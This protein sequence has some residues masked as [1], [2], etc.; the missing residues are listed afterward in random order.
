M[1]VRPAKCSDREL[2]HPVLMVF[3]IEE[4]Y[5]EPDSVHV[6]M[7]T[8]TRMPHQRRNA[9]CKEI[10]IGQNDDAGQRHNQNS[11]L[12]LHITTVCFFAISADICITVSSGFFSG[13]SAPPSLSAWTA[14]SVGIL[15]IISSCA[16]GQPPSP[17]MAE[18][19]RRQP[20]SYAAI[21]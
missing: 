13:T 10:R 1:I 3:F 12:R 11:S 19:N 16:N 20:A 6:Y 5:A 2:I 21:I 14:I 7:I 17:P 15:P 8:M 9:S 18:S 4:R